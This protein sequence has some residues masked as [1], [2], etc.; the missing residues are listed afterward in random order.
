M[1][2]VG[3]PAE[4]EVSR[5]GCFMTV[6]RKVNRCAV[7]GLPEA[8]IGQLPFVGYNGLSGPLCEP[9][10]RAAAGTAAGN[11]IEGQQCRI[12]LSDVI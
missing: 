7:C 3:T 2:I 6:P 5:R 8:A 9:V 1:R 10:R 12:I 4:S 11:R